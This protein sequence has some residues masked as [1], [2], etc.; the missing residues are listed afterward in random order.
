MAIKFS[1]IP[2][3][4]QFVSSIKKGTSE[5]ISFATSFNSSLVYPK[6]QSLFRPFKTVAALELPRPGQLQL[7][8]FS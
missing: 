2:A 6:F 3:P 1:P 4:K 7:V 8:F 5:P